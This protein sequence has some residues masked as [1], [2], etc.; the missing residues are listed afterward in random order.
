MK[1]PLKLIVVLFLAVAPFMIM[2]S[3]A[4][5]K[6]HESQ[7]HATELKLN[8]GQKWHANEATNTRVKTMQNLSREF[9]KSDKK[10][11]AALSNTMQTQIDS[12]VAGCRMTGADHD[13]LHHWLMPVL[14]YVKE[15]RD[16]DPKEAAEAYAKLDNQLTRYDAYFE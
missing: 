14:H 3:H 8:N 9:H 10:D 13:A 5:H 11:Y 4:Q 6:D 1:T 2:P 12:L 15:L 16:D 7:D